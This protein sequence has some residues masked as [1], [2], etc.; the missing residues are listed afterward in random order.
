M[1]AWFEKIGGK[2]LELLA[3]TAAPAASVTCLHLAQSAT[4]GSYSSCS[5]NCSSRSRSAPDRSDLQ[6]H[7]QPTVSTN[8]DDNKSSKENSGAKIRHACVSRCERKMVTKH[9]SRCR[10]VTKHASWCRTV[11][12]AH[13]E[14]QL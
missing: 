4:H 6:I 14:C 12:E 3:A 5:S 8:L 2:E 7:H 10:T 11:T 13:H 1:Q 9:A